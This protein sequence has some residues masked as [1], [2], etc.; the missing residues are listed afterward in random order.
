MPVKSS[1][2]ITETSDT[3]RISQIIINVDGAYVTFVYHKGYKDAKGNWVYTRNYEYT[4]TPQ[5]MKQLA[6]SMPD[7]TKNMYDNIALKSYQFLLNKGLIEGT[8]V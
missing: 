1:Q 7:N 6:T 4:T 3:W 2:P 8:I 5:E